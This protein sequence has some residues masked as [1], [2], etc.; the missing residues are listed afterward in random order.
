MMLTPPLTGYRT[1]TVRLANNTKFKGDAAGR[2]DLTGK[3]VAW[4]GTD[5]ADRYREQCVGPEH[6]STSGP[7]LGPFT[8]LNTY[9]NGTMDIQ[10]QSENQR[11]QV[12]IYKA[13]AKYFDVTG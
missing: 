10:Q 13:P 11:E 6:L 1:A 7:L 12:K 3:T 9:S 5:K 2:E 8:V 4:D